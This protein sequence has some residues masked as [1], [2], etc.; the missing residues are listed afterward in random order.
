SSSLMASPPVYPAPPIMP[1][2][3]VFMPLFFVGFVNLVPDHGLVAEN[4]AETSHIF[5]A[6]SAVHFTVLAEFAAHQ[7]VGRLDAGYLETVR[8]EV[9]KHLAGYVF[10][11][12]LQVRF[13]VAHHRVEYLA[14]VHP[15]AVEG[16]Q[17]V[18]PG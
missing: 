5:P 6:P 3:L 7:V 16:S 10:L 15:V 13:D 12:V 2:F 14:F 4:L 8:H 18:F 1:A 17:L 9:D 11:A